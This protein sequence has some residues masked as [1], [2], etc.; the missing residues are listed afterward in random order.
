MKEFDNRLL[1]W[2]KRRK[3]PFSFLANLLFHFHSLEKGHEKYVLQIFAAQNVFIIGIAK[4]KGQYTV[5]P[6]LFF[7][8]GCSLIFWPKLLMV[9]SMCH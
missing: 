1:V 8:I 7:V 4:L 9:Y 2:T 6:K 3:F 5:K